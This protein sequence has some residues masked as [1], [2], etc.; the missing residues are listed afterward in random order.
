MAR[1]DQAF[2]PY[3][4]WLGIPRDR[5]PPTHYDLLGVRLNEE[6][7]DVI[8]AAAEQRRNF[9]ESQR[10]IGEDAAVEALLYQLQEAEVTLTDPQLR[11]D[12]DQRTKLFVRRSKRRRVDPNAERSQVG[13]LPGRTVG[14]GSGIVRTFVGLMVVFGVGFSAVAWFS[15][16]LPWAGSLTKKAPRS[17]PPITNAEQAAEEEIAPPPLG[18]MELIYLKELDFPG[19]PEDDLWVT[20]DGMTVYWCSPNPPE[21][22]LWIHVA[23][24][25]APGKP[26]DPESIRPLYPGLDPTVTGDGLEMIYLKPR[27]GGADLVRRRRPSQEME[28]GE[29]ERIEELVDRFGFLGAPCLAEDGLTLYVDRM[30]EGTGKSV[31]LTRVNSLARGTVHSFST[32]ETRDAPWN[33]PQ[34]VSFE[35]GAPVIRFAHVANNGRCIVA[36]IVAQQNR[37]LPNLVVFL[38]ETLD[39]P[40]R[41]QGMVAVEDVVVRGKFPRFVPATN[42]LYLS[43]WGE[44]NHWTPGVVRNFDPERIGE[45]RAAPSAADQ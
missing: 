1:S 45:E 34:P 35:E 32:R 6:D 36:R 7:G 16:Q 30:D 31:P 33:E 37:D 19:R 2:D 20:G 28:F 24:R 25:P 44:D 43:T 10:G 17:P 40:F 9:V 38:R 13:A 27:R 15:F 8:R 14:E 39:E 5:R 4:K 11:R 26:F 21:N 29:E 3:H 41:V 22:G 23:H 12:Y 42:E 18:D